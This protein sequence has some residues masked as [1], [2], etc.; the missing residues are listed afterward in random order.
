MDPQEF[1]AE[2]AISRKIYYV[3]RFSDRGEVAL[4]LDTKNHKPR[5]EGDT[6]HFISPEGFHSININHITKIGRKKFH[7]K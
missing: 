6:F 1:S 3:N 5:V 4:V 7:G 2:K